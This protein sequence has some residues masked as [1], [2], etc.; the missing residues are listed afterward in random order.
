MG[1][2]EISNVE[3][4]KSF[5]FMGVFGRPADNLQFNEKR[6]KDTKEKVQ[7]AQIYKVLG[8]EAKTT[9]EEVAEKKPIVKI[10]CVGDSCTYGDRSTDPATKSYPYLL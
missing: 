9:I 2:Q 7:I 5:V 4:H 1:S 8:S 6:A 10:A 3:Y